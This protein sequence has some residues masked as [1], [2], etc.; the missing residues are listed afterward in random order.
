M[1]NLPGI[2][3]IKLKSLVLFKW[4]TVFFPNSAKQ[5]FTSGGRRFK[6]I[7]TN[8][9]PPWK[10]RMPLVKFILD[11]NV[12]KGAPDGFWDILVLSMATLWM[13]AHKIERR[14]NVRK[15]IYT[16]QVRAQ[17]RG[18]NTNFKKKKILYLNGPFLWD[19]FQNI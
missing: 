9:D 19:N 7:R 12:L 8:G 3:P 6:V 2:W 16:S 5:D 10:K 15:S 1:K 11:S 18:I 13:Q 17:K 14:L 4:V